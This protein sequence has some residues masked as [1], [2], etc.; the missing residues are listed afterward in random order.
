MLASTVWVYAG[1][2][3][4]GPHDEDAPFHLPSAGHIYSSSKIAGELIAH[5][6][7]ELY[8]HAVHDPPLRDPVRPEDAASSS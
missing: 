6:Y 2:H 1:A 5:N 4:D 3:G 8:D 7:N